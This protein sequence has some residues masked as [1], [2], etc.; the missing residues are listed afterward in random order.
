MISVLTDSSCSF[1]IDGGVSVME[2]RKYIYWY[3]TLV[4]ALNNSFEGSFS[5]QG[6]NERLM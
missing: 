3:I 6:L 4:P 2:R 5:L 1:M